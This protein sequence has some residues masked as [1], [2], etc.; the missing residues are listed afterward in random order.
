MEESAVHDLATFETHEWI[1]FLLYSENSYFGVAPLQQ[2]N[3][4]Q[5]NPA[6][7]RARKDWHIQN[8]FANVKYLQLVATSPAH[9]LM[10]P[11]SV[12][13]QPQ[14]SKLFIELRDRF[15]LDPPIMYLDKPVAHRIVDT[16]NP[17]RI[18]FS[19]S[20]RSWNA[21]MSL[22]IVILEVLRDLNNPPPA[23]L[24]QAMA[25]PGAMQPRPQTHPYNYTPT[26]TTTTTPYRHEQAQP[27]PVPNN[28]STLYQPPTMQ[29]GGSSS[30]I[31]GNNN[32]NNNQAL[33][34]NNLA[35]ARIQP[36]ASSSSVQDSGSPSVGGQPSPYT[37]TVPARI[38]Q[39]ESKTPAELEVIANDDVE[40]DM[41][42]QSVDF[43]QRAKKQRD[44]LE[45]TL[46]EQAKANLELEEP[47]KKLRLDVE[48][49]SRE[50][51]AKQAIVEALRAQRSEIEARFSPQALLVLL[52]KAVEAADASSE[53]LADQMLEK[54]VEW[55]DFENR[56]VAARQKYHV[57]KIKH[58]WMSAK[59]VRK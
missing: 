50:V 28:A 10:V 33:T 24:Q 3:T 11:F 52:G 47:L 27:L 26:L 17:T 57:R 31:Y 53:D 56:Y 30:N 35:Q 12:P 18:A 8:S 16:Q 38:P 32:N 2:G 59:T 45:D 36:S 41:F 4:R 1:D 46:V 29:S 34:S 37:V 43:V 48:R 42:V 40:L 13:Y 25:A 39:L 15:P 19:D 58:E 5:M 49:L 22:S 9:I 55:K 20:L 54:R 21:S 14:P 23:P 44:D 7:L 6:D 51:A